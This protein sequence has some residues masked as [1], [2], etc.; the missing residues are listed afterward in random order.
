MGTLKKGLPF[1]FPP[2]GTGYSMRFQVLQLFDLQTSNHA[3][4]LQTKVIVPFADVVKLT[5][6]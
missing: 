4:P 5:F 2:F 1:G 6:P 3:E